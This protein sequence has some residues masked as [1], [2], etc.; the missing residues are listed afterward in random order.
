MGEPTD[1]DFSISST[2]ASCSRT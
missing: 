1:E 2:W